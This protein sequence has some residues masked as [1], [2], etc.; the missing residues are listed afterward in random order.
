MVSLVLFSWGWESLIKGIYHP[1]PSYLPNY[2]F[3][4]LLR[5]VEYTLE[6]LKVFLVFTD[7]YLIPICISFIEEHIK[8]AIKIDSNNLKFTE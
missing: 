2:F 4:Y 5:L 8:V 7:W 6:F 1:L 3:A